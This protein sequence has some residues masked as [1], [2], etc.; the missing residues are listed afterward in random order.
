[1]PRLSSGNRARK[2]SVWRMDRVIKNLDNFAKDVPSFN[3]K[4]ESKVRTIFGGLMTGAV[5]IIALAYAT[6]K[7]IDLIGRDYPNVN[8]NTLPSYFDVTETVNVNEIGFRF[9]FTLENFLDNTKKDDPQFIK[10]LAR[11]YYRNDSKWYEKILPFHKCTA[12][13]FSDFFP[14]AKQS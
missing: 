4:G 10:W 3:I 7:M 9:A 6:L 8:I 11:L 12:K 1:M 13:D 5:I 14:V 2:E